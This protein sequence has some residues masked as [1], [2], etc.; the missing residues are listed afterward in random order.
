MSYYKDALYFQVA[1]AQHLISLESEDHV[2]QAVQ[3]GN[4]MS[5]EVFK[6]RG[7]GGQR[8]I[9]A[10]HPG[11]LGRCEGGQRTTPAQHSGIFGMCERGQMA[12]PAQPGTRIFSPLA[13]LF[14][15]R[16]IF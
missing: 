12:T 8:A 6:V 7:E 10:Q 15:F 5:H 13:D 1:K 4:Y 2:Q 14:I 3:T 11:E 16:P 9:P